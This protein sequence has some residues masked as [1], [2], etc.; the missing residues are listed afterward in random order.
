MV[1]TGAFTAFASLPA[2][3][4][5][6]TSPWAGRWCPGHGLPLPVASVPQ[7]DPQGMFTWAKSLRIQHPSKPQQPPRE[8]KTRIQAWMVNACKW[9]MRNCGSGDCPGRTRLSP[10][11]V[12]RGP[13]GQETFRR[14]CWP[15]PRALSKL[16][17]AA[18]YTSK[19]RCWVWQQRR[20][21]RSS[22]VILQHVC[23][24]EPGALIASYSPPF[25]LPQ[26]LK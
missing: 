10:M 13:A 19:A 3:V 1:R 11:E 7:N 15:Q 18:L 5:P 2:D 4:L 9:E 8:L 12:T 23:K 25:Q 14:H 20:K 17:T 16:K 21:W 26:V 22:L 24:H 6:A